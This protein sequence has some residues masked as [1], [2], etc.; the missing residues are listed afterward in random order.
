MENRR[1]KQVILRVRSF[2]GRQLGL[3]SILRLQHNG[4]DRIQLKRDQ[5]RAIAFRNSD[6]IIEPLYPEKSLENL[7]VIP[8]WVSEGRE[9]YRRGLIL[10]LDLAVARVFPESTLWVEHS[11][12]LGYRCSLDNGPDIE[13]EDLV[14]RLTEELSSVIKQGIPI[15]NVKLEPDGKKSSTD[16]LY[17]WHS[18]NHVYRM[19]VLDKSK[20]FAMGPAA[21]D[22]SWLE[23]WELKPQDGAFVLRFPGSAYWPDIGPW[24]NRPRLSREYD[25]EERHISRMRARTISEL[26]TRIEEDGGLELVIMSHFYQNYRIVE[27][28]KSL[29]ENFPRKRVITIA[30]PSSSGKTTIARLLST[31]LRAQGFGARMISVDNYFR[32]RSET[33]LDKDG[34]PD[35]ECLEA[36]ETEM[37]G[38]DLQLLLHGEEVMLPEFDFHTGE[39]RDAVLPMRLESNEFLLIEG[40]HG[41]NDQLTPGVD[42]GDKFRMYVSAL[43]QLNIDRLTRMSTSDSRLIRRIVRDSTSRGY[44]AHETIAHWPMVR[45][46]ERRYIFPFQE[47]A[48]AIFNSSLPYEL[49]VLK[50]FAVP[51]LKKVPRGCDEYNTANRLLRLFDC[52]STIDSSIV[53]R[54]SLLREFIEGSLLDEDGD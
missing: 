42:P 7:E 49:P 36:L 41:L 34:K 16:G 24:M 52:V 8:P 32:N 4:R 20:A 10:A 51:L 6:G 19:N 26:N 27:I 43:T 48:D 9:V 14:K 29:E 37:F 46:G 25:L 15:Q 54:L 39:R 3:S 11:L 21:P 47:Q 28:V 33:P 35:Y 40:I 17:K 5:K 45:R 38:R 22:T 50:P 2:P 31:Y 30:G 23:K 1:R 18:G 12:S 13:V 53:P 44:S